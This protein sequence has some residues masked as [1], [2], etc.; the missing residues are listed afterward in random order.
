MSESYMMLVVEAGRSRLRL[1]RR[2]VLFVSNLE[3]EDRRLYTMYGSMDVEVSSPGKL[4]PR[5]PL[6]LGLTMR[7]SELGQRVVA[8]LLACSPNLNEKA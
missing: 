6:G 8:K 3:G 5:T 4:F 2:I 7:L 1:L